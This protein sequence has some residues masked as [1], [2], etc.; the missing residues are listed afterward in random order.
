MKELEKRIAR[1][2]RHQRRL[3]WLLVGLAILLFLIGM[4]IYGRAF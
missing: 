4:L 3:H 2:E 1:L